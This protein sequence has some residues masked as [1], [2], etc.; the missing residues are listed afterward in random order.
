MVMRSVQA[1]EHGMRQSEL[2]V[3]DG[4][5]MAH[6]QLQLELTV[7]VRE[8]AR[9]QIAHWNVVAVPLRWTV[10]CELYLHFFF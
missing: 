4:A 6:A 2:R 9:M 7:G 5:H 3:E 10:G 1:S 8:V